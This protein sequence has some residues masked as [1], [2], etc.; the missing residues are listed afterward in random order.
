MKKLLS[1]MSF[2]LGTALLIHSPAV[3]HIDVAID[4]NVS[5]HPPISYVIVDINYQI[6]HIVG[7]SQKSLVQNKGE[8]PNLHESKTISFLSLSPKQVTG[9]KISVQ[10]DQE[11]N[12]CRHTIEIKPPF[13]LF[14][15]YNLSDF[16]I[17]KHCKK[18]KAIHHL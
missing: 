5:K 15:I 11:H 7:F 8:L 17:P 9:M 4:N 2:V 3:A 16:P 6:G 13:Q 14:Y 12:Y 18:P 1:M 10:F